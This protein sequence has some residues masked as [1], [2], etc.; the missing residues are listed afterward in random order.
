MRVFKP[1]STS[2]S[3]RNSSTVNR[4]RTLI[5]DAQMPRPHFQTT[6]DLSVPQDYN[7]AS[8][9]GR[10][11]RPVSWHPSS[12][13]QHAPSQLQQYISLPPSTPSMIADHGNYFGQPH[14]S[15]L[16][17]SYSNETSPTSTFSPLPTALNSAE[18]A[19]FP[20]NEGWD[21]SQRAPDTYP[22]NASHRFSAG[23]DQLLANPAMG[24]TSPDQPFDWNS[25]VTQ[26]YHNTTPPTPEYIPHLREM[27]PASMADEPLPYQPLDEPE[28]EGEILVGMGL[29]D[30]PE[31]TQDDPQLNNYR[32]TVTSL[33]GTHFRPDEP[34]GRGLKLEET[35][36]PPKSE[37]V[38]DAE[39]GDEDA[40]GSPEA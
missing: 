4:R 30:T 16:M 3:P 35:W 31:K 23:S 15:P 2:N 39:E 13:V 40:E 34:Q 5:H 22:V 8:R 1:S 24:N 21:F 37:E 9:V 18:A 27:K 10:P 12:Q 38:D 20:S 11:A 7:M 32:S 17:V 25:F 6:E 26:G 29:Y 36:E 14:F 19:S 33:L 28:E